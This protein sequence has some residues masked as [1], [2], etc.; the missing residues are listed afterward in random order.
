MQNVQSATTQLLTL[1]NVSALKSTKR[2]RLDEAPFAPGRKLNARNKTGITT[3]DIRTIPEAIAGIYGEDGDVA[4]DSN[5]DEADE[6][7]APDE[8]ASEWPVMS[9]HPLRLIALSPRP[10]N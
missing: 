8:E 1:L 4:M 10:S 9:I 2:K 5:E 7:G 3:S 6:G